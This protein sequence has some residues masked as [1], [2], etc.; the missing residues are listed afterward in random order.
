[1][2]VQFDREVV[3]SGYNL[4]KINTNFERIQTALGEA[5]SRAGT[6]PNFMENDLDLNSNDVLNGGAASFT[7]LLVNGLPVSG[8]TQ[9]SQLEDVVL[10]G[11]AT[12]NFLRWNGTVWAN[13]VL[14]NYALA[15]ANTDISSLLGITG[16]IGTADYLDFDTAATPSKAVGRF[17][18]DSTIGSLSLGMTGGN[19]ST[20]IGNQM[21]AFV[22]N[23]ESVT[24]NKGQPVYMYGAQGDRLSVK[25]AYNTSDATSAKT[26]GL[27]AENIAAGQTGY[28]ITQGVLKNVNTAAYNPGDTLYLGATAGTITATKP[29]APNHLVYIGTVARANAGGGEIYVRAQN[30]YELDEIHDVSALSPTNGDT[31]R[32]NSSTSLW[33]KFP[34]LIMSGDFGS[35]GNSGLVPA[36]AVGDGSK[37]L[38]GDGT[39]Q[40]VAG[41]GTVTSVSVVSANGLAGTVSTATTTP[42]ITLSTTITGVLKGN[43]TAI[44][45]ATA[46]TDYYAPGSTDVA[47]ADGGTGASTASG[48][49]DNLGLGTANS[50]QFTGIELGNVSD[51]TITRPSAG[52][53]AVEGNI[54]YRAG[55]TD[56]PVTD[57]G[58]GSSTAAGARTNLGLGTT[59]SPQFTGIE[60]GNA[61]DTTITR[62]SA[63]NIAIE[64]N[65]VYRAG[66]TDV[67]L[68]DGGTGS[69]LVDPNADRIMFW[70]DSVNL[71]DWLAPTGKLFISGT[72]I[73]TTA[74][75][76]LLGTLTTTSGT[77][78]TLTGITSTYRYLYI[79]F[80]AVSF[81]ST[82]T[83]AIATST[84]GTTFGTAVNITSALAAA[85][86]AFNGFMILG[87]IQLTTASVKTAMCAISNNAGAP[88]PTV[89]AISANA[90]GAVTA[91]RFSGGTFD[92]GS[93]RIYGMN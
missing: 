79:E 23:A 4:S 3:G 50:P 9:L 93:I 24:I 47:V 32:W 84:D 66:G 56:V 16:G 57:G 67:A 2:S 63:G 40:V 88:T 53:I 68:A 19:V 73:D 27:A 41:T 31:I 26:L 43:G 52:D 49:R 51:T 71:V 64:G 65:I 72:N 29:Y 82:N 1:M 10:T 80:D 13:Y 6:S 22:T 42:A 77:T 81:A 38:R 59:D 34:L 35:G 28:I 17:M 5:L 36:Q 37:F 20:Q 48:A 11:L 70:R 85:G 7:S 87:N 86:N 45:A 74:G 33:E 76:N 90:V 25:L 61:T 44:S 15:G 62:P 89:A 75:L 91:I 12:G 60:L 39:W 46:G 58:T 30:G 14:P 69:S 18:W 8:I 92:A 54:V 83:L 55:G 21:Y 78:Q